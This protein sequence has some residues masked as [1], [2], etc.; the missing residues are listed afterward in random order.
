MFEYNCPK[1]A[2]PTILAMTPEQMAKESIYTQNACTYIIDKIKKIDSAPLRKQLEE[3]YQNN[4]FKFLKLYPDFKSKEALRQ[5]LIRK[6]FL[7]SSVGIT[8]FMP[9]GENITPIWAA[10]GS[11][12]RGHHAHPGG[13]V[14]HIEENLRMSLYLAKIYKQMYNLDFDK[15]MLIF[16]QTTHDLAKAW[17]AN[18]KEDGSVLMQ[19]A[20]ADTG[21]HHIFGLAESICWGASPEFLYCQA[22]VHLQSA[23]KSARRI[24]IDF[25]LAAFVIAQKNPVEYGLLDKEGNLTFDYRKEEFWFCN[26][27]DQMLF[28]VTA[29]RRCIKALHEL[30]QEEYA[31]DEKALSGKPFNQLR[32]YLFSQLSVAGC[33][34]LLNQHGKQGLKKKIA[35]IIEF[36]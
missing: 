20:L 4:S 2:F 21:V 16:A 30:A 22:S 23:N 26:M 34:A 32:N 1:K 17:L 15:D 14:I 7:S 35:T 11:G 27:G 19:Y 31:F 33:F 10:S 12:Y 8:Q 13:L 9:S 3:R 29:L 5:E 6:G 25:L 36:N 28:T 18:W 24:I